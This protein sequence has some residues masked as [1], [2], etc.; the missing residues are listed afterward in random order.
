MPPRFLRGF[1]ALETEEQILNAGSLVAIVGVFLPWMSGEWLGGERVNYWGFEFYTSILGFS[2]FLLHF[3]L[4]IITLVP[5]LGGPVLIR[6]RHREAVRLAASGAA[7]LLILAALSVLMNVTLEFTRMEMRFGIY[8]SLIGSLVALLYS[9]LRFQEMR[10]QQV[11]EL[12]HHPEDRTVPRE[13]TET[14]VAP[15]PP[16]PPPPPAPEEHR[17][18][19]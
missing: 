9:F 11:Q 17:L 7:A 1:A 6:K 10:K 4:L 19:P 3:F 15:P 13:N 8:V 14:Y 18:Y 12:F 5:L 2:V 16:P